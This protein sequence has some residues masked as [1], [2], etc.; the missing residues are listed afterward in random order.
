VASVA[1]QRAS[2]PAVAKKT[3]DAIEIVVRNARLAIEAGDVR[4]V[5]QLLDMNQMLLAGL[6]LSTQ[7]IESMCQT[8][9]EQG[10]LGAKLTGA[11]GGGCVIALAETRAAAERVLGAWNAAGRTSFITEV[12]APR[13]S[14]APHADAGTEAQP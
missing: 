13:P 8:A 1:R 7:E 3:F 6:L 10:A 4:A 12:A 5:G 11:G 2:R 9:R 14:R